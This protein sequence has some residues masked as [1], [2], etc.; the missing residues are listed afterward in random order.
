MDKNIFT[1][2]NKYVLYSLNSKIYNKYVIKSLYEYFYKMND[3][4]NLEKVF[5]HIENITSIIIIICI[6]K[7]L[8]YIYQVRLNYLRIYYTWII[9]KDI[10]YK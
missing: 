4:N 5:N 10:W 3:V 2:V 1:K 8:I 6:I 9:F 7:R